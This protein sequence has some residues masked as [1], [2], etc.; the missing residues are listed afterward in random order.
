MNDVAVY[1]QKRYDYWFYNYNL[2][3]RCTLSKWWTHTINIIFL[4]WIP[5]TS[6]AKPVFSEDSLLVKMGSNRFSIKHIRDVSLDAFRL[7]Y[8]TH[9]A[10]F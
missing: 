9:L 6:K 4:D 1:D 5:T 7:R 8:N 2:W 3:I 10:F